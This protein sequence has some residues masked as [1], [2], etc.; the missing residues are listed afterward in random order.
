MSGFYG[1]FLMH[2]LYFRQIRRRSNMEAGLRIGYIAAAVIVFLGDVAT[3][4]FRL[5]A[6]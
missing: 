4:A 3:S 6:K 2:S 1:V 5:Q